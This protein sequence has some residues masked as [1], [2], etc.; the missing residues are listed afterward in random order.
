MKQLEKLRDVTIQ[1]KIKDIYLLG[2]ISGFIGVIAMD[3]VGLILFATKKMELTYGHLTAGIFVQHLRAIR[4][5]FKANFWIG[6]IFH[7]FNGMGLG[8]GIANLF[9]KTGKKY[10][11]IKGLMLGGLIWQ[12]LYGIGTSLGPLRVKP[13]LAKSHYSSLLINLL[14]GIVTSQAIVSLAH[15]SVFSDKPKQEKDSTLQGELKS[16][17]K[18]GIVINKEEGNTLEQYTN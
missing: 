4:T 9:K 15:P 6:E 5:K 17:Y 18:E 11:L 7:I 2:A 12:V 14:F 3:I 16:S 10:H 8:V 13:N 1:G